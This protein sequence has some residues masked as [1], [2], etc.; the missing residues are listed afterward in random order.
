[1][2]LMLLSCALAYFLPFELF[3]FSYAI[4]GPLHYL[5]E[6]VWLHKKEYFS[7]GKY[8]YL[9]LGGLALLIY[10]VGYEISFETPRQH[11]MWSAGVVYLAF[12]IAFALMLFSKLGSRFAFIAI[13]CFV[14]LVIDKKI[15]S[16]A[17]FIR[18]FGIFLPTLVHVFI[19][20]G[21]FILVG[22]LKNKQISSVLSL[23][24]FLGC[25][26]SFFL[27]IPKTGYEA[28][29]YVQNSYQ[30]FASVNV[31]LAR[32][33]SFPKLDYLNVYSSPYSIAIAR[34]VSFAYT[35]HY[36]NWFSKTSVIQWHKIPKLQLSVIIGMW[37]IAIVLYGYSYAIGLKALYILSFMHVFLEFPL[38]HH[39]FLT[40]GKALTSKWTKTA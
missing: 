20:T 19:F 37:I 13:A 26:L 38:N 7:K 3:L 35:Y 1:M 6:I 34:F 14:L 32:L 27:F 16:P 40:V 23:I 30:G 24:V 4:L 31:E 18:L 2:G 10:V 29:T 11:Y 12:V 25:A 22:A 28:S 15:E 17:S 39:S 9:L 5:T 21:I 8:D 36:L 33:L